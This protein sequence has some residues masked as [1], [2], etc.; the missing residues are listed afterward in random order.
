MKICLWGKCF[1]M[2]R[3]ID[4]CG[5]AGVEIVAILDRNP[6][7]C[8]VCSLGV[9]TVPP[10]RLPDLAPDYVL[11]TCHSFEEV[12]D[13]AVAMGYP[14]ERMLNYNK[15]PQESMALLG[16]P[17]HVY[18]ESYEVDADGGLKVIRHTHE[19]LGKTVGDVETD[20]PFERQLEIAA[21]LLKAFNRAREDAAFQPGVYSVGENWGEVLR[22]SRGPL[23]EAADRADAEG[24]ARL[25][26][27]F[28]RNS[29]SDSIVG[30]EAGFRQFVASAHDT[31]LQHNLE[32]WMALVDA[33]ASVADAGMPPVGNPYGYVIDGHVINWNSFVNHGRAYR[34]LKLLADTGRDMLAEI[35]G[36]FGGFA[37]NVLKQAPGVT[38]L[39][40]DLPEN[41][42]LAS[43]YMLMAHPNKKVL[44]YESQDMDM[45][46][47]VLGC[48]DAV[49]LPNFMLPRMHDA[50]VGLIINTISLSEMDHSTV[51]EYFKQAARV[52]TGYFYHENLSCHPDYKG[53]PTSVFPETPGLKEIFCGFS[54]WMGFDAYTKGHS[55]LERI[56][57]RTD[58]EAHPWERARQ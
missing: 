36:G 14:R 13:Q 55:Y 10:S 30:G 22:K 29:L 48:Y 25:L 2:E 35:G 4:S 15:R 5:Q 16:S 47:A 34:C 56:L 20:V 57:K 40:F 37:N 52:T 49:M 19:V 39:D 33:S 18:H 3:V 41:L 7:K 54:P 45:T 8:G 11:V 53:Y 32:V 38:Y 42:L 24:L 1:G 46:P 6:G 51:T 26:S 12:C 28:F 17:M 31:W 58:R 9:E 44:L 21:R 23:Y 27:C 43:Y 50:S